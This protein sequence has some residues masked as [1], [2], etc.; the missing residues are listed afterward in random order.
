M[1]GAQNVTV[2]QG[3][4]VR[5]RA[6]VTLGAEALA[7]RWGQEEAVVEKADD[8]RACANH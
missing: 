2:G 6:K 1:R 7:G 8:G 5:S 3:D 4:W